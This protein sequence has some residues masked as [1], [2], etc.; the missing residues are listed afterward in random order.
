MDK[1][2]TIHELVATPKSARTR[3]RSAVAAPHGRHVHAGYL[4]QKIA[5]GRTFLGVTKYNWVS[6]YFV[7]RAGTLQRFQDIVGKTSSEQP[8]ETYDLSGATLK[9]KEQKHEIV[10][11][12][13]DQRI[14]PLTVRTDSR[15]LVGGLWVPHLNRHIE[16]A[17]RMQQ[18]TRELQDRIMMEGT[19][20]NSPSLSMPSVHHP[21][22]VALSVAV[23]G[24]GLRRSVCGESSEFT[25]H[26]PNLRNMYLQGR[27]VH[28]SD[29]W[30]DHLTAELLLQGETEEENVHADVTLMFDD[31]EVDETTE[32]E[33][34]GVI[35]G[36]Y[37]VDRSGIW[38]LHVRYRD[39]HAFGSPFPVRV[40]PAEIDP[41]KS[42]LI[43]I[44]NSSLSN[45][46]LFK[47]RLCDRFGNA[48]EGQNE[49][50]EIA[51]MLYTESGNVVT[52]EVVPSDNA[53]DGEY[54]LRY[55]ISSL[56]AEDEH[57]ST[58]SMQVTVCGVELP[59]APFD[60]TVAPPREA[61]VMTPSNNSI[62]T[63]APAETKQTASTS[64]MEE[65]GRSPPAVDGNNSRSNS[66]SKD[67]GNSLWGG[68][69]MGDS[70]T[71]LA[72]DSSPNGGLHREDVLNVVQSAARRTQS[73]LTKRPGPWAKASELAAWLPPRRAMVEEMLMPLLR[74]LEEETKHSRGFGFSPW[75]HKLVKF[76]RL[77]FDVPF[78]MGQRPD[79]EDNKTAM[80]AG[81]SGGGALTRDP[82]WSRGEEVLFCELH[83]SLEVSGLPD[84]ARTVM[85]SV[86]ND[87]MEVQRQLVAATTIRSNVWQPDSSSGMRSSVPVKQIMRGAW[88]SPDPPL[89][90]LLDPITR[91]GLSPTKIVTDGGNRENGEG[92]VTVGEV[93][94]VEGQVSTTTRSIVDV[95][96]WKGRREHDAKKKDAEEKVEETLNEDAVRVRETFQTSPSQGIVEI[97]SG[98]GRGSIGS[99]FTYGLTNRSISPESLFATPIVTSLD[100][101]DHNETEEN[102]DLTETMSI[103][104]RYGLPPK[105]TTEPEALNDLLRRL[106]SDSVETEEERRMLNEQIGMEREESQRF[107]E[108]SEQRPSQKLVDNDDMMSYYD[109]D[110]D[111]LQLLKEE[112]F[113]NYSE[114]T[115]N[116]DMKSEGSEEVETE[117]QGAGSYA[118]LT[119][120]KAKWMRYQ[121]TSLTIQEVCKK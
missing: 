104:K 34:M 40:T 43:T 90:S 4:Q 67:T 30:D 19:G 78:A 80:G 109:E 3:L 70:S 12:F 83:E 106:V 55:D 101:E 98:K 79:G 92:R 24:T 93:A 41:I 64:A 6:I 44:I 42:E 117:Y 5:N 69:H 66:D 65:A 61:M 11:I 50:I 73:E 15:Y 100:E 68:A 46:R 36:K 114:Y 27:A 120:A 91:I 31:D 85:C 35:R 95:N 21:R 29:D 47:V 96:R 14:S 38:G 107:Q 2:P 112:N 1:K 22:D 51:G 99:T 77:Y 54:L 37:A 115:L 84:P 7:L 48:R 81:S 86:M 32:E 57:N 59:G 39:H 26:A 108:I 52:C 49:G 113:M 23:E 94:S 121:S 103:S 10:I 76:A 82:R 72:A 13:R 116:A 87:Y 74:S 88:Q 25:V 119:W 28:G 33:D 53:K 75:K 56:L 9:V 63:G 71:S 62:D 118:Q 58:R 89:P 111:M 20:S 102:G 17:D 97:E 110:Q 18:E 8:D 45:E 60:I 105:S 16:N